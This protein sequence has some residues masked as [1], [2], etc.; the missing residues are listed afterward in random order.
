MPERELITRRPDSDPGTSLELTSTD[1]R[2]HAAVEPRGGG[3]RALTVDGCA[4]V[5]SYADGDRPPYAAG[6][7]LFPWPNR[8]RD[9]RWSA[10]GTDH[11]L[12]VDE[13]E[14][15]NAS[16]GLVRDQQ[17]ETEHRAGDVV[18][19]RTVVNDR[20]GYPFHLQ[21]TIEYR[22]LD[23]GLRVRSQVRNLGDRPAPFALGF[24]PYLRLGEVPTEQLWLQVAAEEVLDVD[25]RLIP[26]GSRAVTAGPQDPRELPLATAVLDH[27]YGGLAVVDG[28]VRH[29]LRAPDGRALELRAEARFGWLQVY[30]CP[31]FPRAEGAGLAVALE[32]MTAPPDALRSGRDLTWLDPGSTWSATWSLH[33]RP[34]S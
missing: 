31:Q 20:P 22:L 4:L 29:R 34:P 33:L 3:L 6:A 14:L 19:L 5:E 18:T 13:P 21:L 23:D 2:V 16:H 17:F 12:D 1:R 32:P 25:H 9:G 28:S 24:H 8:V 27:C 30:T 10:H 7:V 26:V 11:Q 15:R